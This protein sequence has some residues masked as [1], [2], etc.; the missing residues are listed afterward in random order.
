MPSRQAPGTPAPRWA[1][2]TAD[3]DTLR[4]DSLAGKV[5]VLVW[6]DPTCAEVQTA[7]ENGA[8]RMTERRWMQ[9]SRVEIYYVASMAGGGRDWLAPA[10]WK[11]WLKD[12]KLRAPVLV[13]SAQILA[14]AWK[15]KRIPSAGIV[16]A[17]G[18]VRWAGP[19]DAMDSTGEPAVS[20]AIERA[21][22]GA[23]SWVPKFDPPGGCALGYRP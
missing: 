7:A 22:A 19:V 10:D 21:L 6:I 23:N 1:L 18:R 14:E 13:D 3:G 8:L 15:I 16:D 5:V 9:D 17:T 20:T 4:S 2:E 12:M 11:P